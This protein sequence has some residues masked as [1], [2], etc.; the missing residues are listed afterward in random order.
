MC[1]ASELHEL[2]LVQARR[3][4][5]LSSMPTGVW[6]AYYVRS[7]IAR[8]I[9]KRSTSIEPSA[10]TRVAN[11]YF[12]FIGQFFAKDEVSLAKVVLPERFP[13]NSDVPVKGRHRYKPSTPTSVILLPALYGANRFI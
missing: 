9:W 12:R 7:K 1:Q 4:M 3:L 6:P 10:S 13:G 8:R 11:S 2:L 5:H